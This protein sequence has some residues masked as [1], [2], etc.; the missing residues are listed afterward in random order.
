METDDIDIV[1]LTHM[2]W[3]HCQNT[4]LFTKARVLVNPTEIDYARSPNKWD[5]AVAAGMADMMRN[6]KV[7]TVSEGDKVVDGVTIIETPGHTKGHMSILADIDG[8]KVLLAGDAMPESGSIARGLP[9]KSFGTFRMLKKV[10]RKWLLPPTSFIQ[11]MT[12][13]FVL[14]VTK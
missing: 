2:H 6:M 12:A 10:L 1:I 9:Y 13:H 14:K 7:D 3:D 4:D 5:L 11:D 8:E